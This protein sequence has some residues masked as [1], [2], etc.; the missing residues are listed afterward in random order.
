MSTHKKHS[1]D[2][3]D[4]DVLEEIEPINYDEG[5]EAHEKKDKLVKLKEKLK[6]CEKEKQQYLDSWQREK[7]EFQNIRKRDEIANKDAVRRAREDMIT[8][9]LPVFDSFEMAFADTTS[10]QETPEQ[11]R[12]GVEGIYAQ[13]LS[14]LETYDVKPLSPVSEPFDPTYHEAI[15]Q[16]TVTEEKEDGIVLE[17]VQ[18]GYRM[19][20]RLIRTAK[21]KVGNFE[22]GA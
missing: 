2:S 4:E 11:W 13:L 10:Y 16:V 7:A 6:H 21:V 19:G 12:A 22:G 1:Q 8:S 3:E 20:E 14:I 9:L 17:V 18:K 5:S 15:E